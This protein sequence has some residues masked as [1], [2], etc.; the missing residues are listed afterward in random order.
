MADVTTKG[1]LVQQDIPVKW[2]DNGDGTWSLI[3]YNGGASGGGGSTVTTTPV[4]AAT[5]TLAN[6]AGSASS[7]TLIAL[8]TARLG[9]TIVN[10]STAVLYIK[11]GSTASATSY[12]YVVAGSI[13]G[14]GVTWEMPASPRYTGI[15]TGL[16]ASATGNARTNELTA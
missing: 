4:A 14:V 9:A 10:D 16:W 15:I 13:G 3:V 8:N 11:Y 12:N 6:V 5:A 7:V 2:H 1:S